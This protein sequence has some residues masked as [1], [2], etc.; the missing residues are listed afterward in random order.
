MTA[1]IWVFNWQ[2]KQSFGNCFYSGLSKTQII[3]LDYKYV[4]IYKY[5]YKYT[6]K[7]KHIY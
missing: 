7:Y 6:Y 2:Q 4:Y 5:N 3:T 1:S